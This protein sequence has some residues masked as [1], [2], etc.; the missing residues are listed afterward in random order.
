MVLTYIALVLATAA[1]MAFGGFALYVRNMEDRYG[2]LY[3]ISRGHTHNVGLKVESLDRQV[4]NMAELTTKLTF[5]VVKEQ[6]SVALRFAAA[7]D[8]LHAL[9]NA[10]EEINNKVEGKAGSRPPRSVEDAN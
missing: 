2:D 10:I 1:C 4:A 9:L 7:A 8:A 3:A 5:T 6:R